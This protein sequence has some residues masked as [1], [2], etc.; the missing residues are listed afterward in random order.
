MLIEKKKSFFAAHVNI[1]CYRKLQY[2]EK[3]YI[4]TAEIN[5]LNYSYFSAVTEILKL[6]L[7]DKF[8]FAS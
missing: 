2:I 6:L 4:R 8:I 3:N 5:P 7:K 1:L